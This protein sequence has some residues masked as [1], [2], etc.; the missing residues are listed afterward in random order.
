[1]RDNRAYYDVFAETY[2]AP[3]GGRYHR[4][5][6]DAEVALAAPHVADRDVLEVGCGT[7]RILHRLAEVARRAVGVDLSPGML[8]HARE[9]G[10]DVHEANATDL[11]FEDESFDVVVS[12]KVLAHVEDIGRALDEIHRV[13]RPGGKAVLEFYNRRSIRAAVK[14]WGKPGSIGADGATDESQVFTRFDT[15]ATIASYLPDGLRLERH[16]G[17][18]ILSPAAL[19]FHVP[20]FGALWTALERGAMGTPL[21]RWGGF[22]VVTLAKSTTNRAPQD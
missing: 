19:L 21:R 4:F 9:R 13:L 5:V 14:R 18:R 7:G 20:L 10:L 16:D 2:D 15:L 6:D 8:A 11:P 1:M 12:F 17:I 3:R 22:L